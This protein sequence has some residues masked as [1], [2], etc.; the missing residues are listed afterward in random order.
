V[1]GIADHGFA[2]QILRRKQLTRRGISLSWRGHDA[3]QE[4]TGAVD[5]V[6]SPPTVAH[7]LASNHQPILGRS[8]ELI[9]HATAPFDRV[10]IDACKNRVKVVF[11]TATLW[12]ASCGSATRAVGPGSSVA[13]APDL[14]ATRDA[15]ASH[16]RQAVNPATG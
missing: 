15:L 10:V 12:S 7:L 5:G 16:N 6:T 8:Q 11:W 14:G 4:P 9:C 13:Y 2:D 1:Q 3:T